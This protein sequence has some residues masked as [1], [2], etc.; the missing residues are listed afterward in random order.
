MFH[1]LEFPPANVNPTD[2]KL[3]RVYGAPSVPC[4]GACQVIVT[5]VG[6]P[7]YCVAEGRPR[8]ECR[9]FFLTS[10]MIIIYIG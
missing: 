10:R 6:A 4:G 7:A 2:I 8:V 1:P 3:G 5:N 9:L